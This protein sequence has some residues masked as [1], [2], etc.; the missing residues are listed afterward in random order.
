MIRKLYYKLV[1]FIGYSI[2]I[3]NNHRLEDNE[4]VVESKNL[5]VYKYLGR[6]KHDNS[7]RLKRVWTIKI[8]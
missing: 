3:E 1:R 6:F 5:S 7:I 2:R 8:R 4:W